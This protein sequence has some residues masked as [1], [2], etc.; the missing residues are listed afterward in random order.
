AI[1]LL[2]ENILYVDSRN[3]GTETGTEEYPYKTIQKAV[4]SVKDYCTILVKDGSGPYDVNQDISLNEKTMLEIKPNVEIR[5]GSGRLLTITRG[6]LAEYAI[7]TGAT[8]TIG[9]WKGI[10][11]LNSK[12]GTITYCTI[13]YAQQALY[14]ENSENITISYNTISHNKGLGGANGNWSGWSPIYNGGAGGVGCGIALSSSKNNRILKNAISDNTGGNGGKGYECGSDGTGGFGCGIC[15][16]S[17]ISNIVFDNLIRDSIG[18]AGSRGGIGAG[19]C[20]FSSFENTIGLNTIENSQGGGGEYGIYISGSL[21]NEI[22][23][24]NR[25]NGY[26]IHY[27]Y[28]KNNVEIRG[29]AIKAPITNLG[30]VVL[31]ECS[32][33]TITGCKIE[34]MRGENGE[35]GQYDNRDPI[36]GSNGSLGAGIYILS[37]KDGEIF[38]NTISDNIGGGGGAGNGASYNADA[39]NGGIGCGIYLQ[40]STNTTIS[41]NTI[42]QNTGGA[43]GPGSLHGSGGGGGMG[44]GICFSFSTGNTIRGNTI[45]NNQGG[46]GGTGGWHSSAGTG[47]IVA[48]IYLSSS[49]GN[50]I[51]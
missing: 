1:C 4:E 37:S 22:E 30:V 40:S 48:G 35:T 28:K 9:Y 2:K 14:L 44:C 20:L 41:N 34:G 16:S 31:I 42:L 10:K 13:E 29:E 47:G 8:K 7:F 32:S 5:F 49:T 25:Y 6:I 45:A 27:Y 33:F 23:V 24:T 21:N 50:T 46:I 36:K 3:Q 18:G 17:S 12:K 43:G 51:S 39:G 19:I 26:N 38:G 15:L 11:F